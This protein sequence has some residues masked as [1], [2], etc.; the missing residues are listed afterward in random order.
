MI[1]SALHRD[2]AFLQTGSG[3]FV[4]GTGPFT[5]APMA[6]EDGSAAFYLNDFELSDPEPW[7][8]PARCFVAADPRALL[9]D[10]GSTPLP[11]V[12]W[13]GLGDAGFRGVYD[14]IQAEIAAGRLEK[15]VPVITERGWLNGGDPAALVKAVAGLPDELRGYGYRFGDRG[16]V[17]ATPE[18][19]FRV[20]GGCLE[21]MALAG[22]APRHEAGDFLTDPKEIREH[23]F[24]AEYLV[25]KLGELGEIE[26][27]ERGVMD[28]GSL[29]HFLSR[30]RVRL[31]DPRPDLD[32]L[33]R[34]MHPT[35]ALGA[36]PRGEGALRMLCGFRERLQAPPQFGAPFGVLKD[37][38]FT[39]VVAIRH[40]SWRG[41]ELR[42]PSGCGLIRE[43][44]FDREWRELALKRN[45]VK[46]LLGV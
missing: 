8:F 1:D 29:V 6:P 43:S 19:L 45:S 14:E 40:V 10:N 42:L 32:A 4:C 22:T 18:Q 5:S 26:R 11:A 17:G 30:I 36:Y 7:K 23:E 9:P 34:L 25:G 38:V 33:I 15:S 2:F 31:R 44:R 35:P 28:L 27:E 3:R 20:E 37:G 12:E 16:M 21:T 41:N 46:A 39:S 24:V 13:R